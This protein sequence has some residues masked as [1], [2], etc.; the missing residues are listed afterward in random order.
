MLSSLYGH[1]TNN[2]LSETMAWKLLLRGSGFQFVSMKNEYTI[3]KSSTM[4]GWE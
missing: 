4:V 3:E 1:T 2:V